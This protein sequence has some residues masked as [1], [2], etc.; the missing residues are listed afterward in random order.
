MRRWPVILGFGALL[1]LLATQ[2]ADLRE[3]SRLTGVALE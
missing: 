2:V 1:G 3:I